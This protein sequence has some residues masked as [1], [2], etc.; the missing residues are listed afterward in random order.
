VVC[1][2]GLVSLWC[3]VAV[4]SVCGVW[5]LSCESVLSVR[6]VSLSCQSVLCGARRS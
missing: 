6:L 1:G 3:V 5:W 4:L 2:G